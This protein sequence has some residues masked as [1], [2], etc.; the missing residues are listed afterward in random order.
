MQRVINIIIALLIFL[1]GCSDEGT[2]LEPVYDNTF[3]KTVDSIRQKYDFPAMGA[4]VIVDGQVKDLTV[5]GVRKYGTNIPAYKE[6]PFHLGSNSKA[7]TSTLIAKL[8]EMGKLDWNTTLTEIFPEHLHEMTEL[9]KTK[10]IEEILSHHAGFP[11]DVIPEGMSEKDLYNYPGETI[12]QQR[13]NYALEILKSEPQ[14]II[15]GHFQY[16]NAGFVLLGAIAEKVEGESWEALIQKYIFTPLRMV[17][18]GFGNM[19]T[20]GSV[21]A[22]WQ[23]GHD[24]TKIIPYDF[25]L[26]GDILPVLFAPTGRVHLCLEDYSKFIMEH[27]NGAR[28]IDGLLKSATINRLHNSTA[29]SGYSG[30]WLISSTRWEWTNGDALFHGG[31]N[32]HNIAYTIVAPQRNFAVVVVTNALHTNDDGQAMNPHAELVEIL[33]IKYLE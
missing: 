9:Y 24:G 12:M 25:A 20:P 31:S 23:H 14:E 11:H 29:N 16:S 6:D 30:G 33:R 13:S 3:E 8:V 2:I 27:M 4:F 28:G 26:N 1:I 18:A 15:A 7:F 17:R 10:T 5:T 32:H 19:A 22:P 21:D